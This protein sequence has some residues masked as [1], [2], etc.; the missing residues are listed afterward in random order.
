MTQR[1]S[2]VS[3][4][5]AITLQTGNLR[6]CIRILESAYD[7]LQK[8]DA[9]DILYDIYR[10]ACVKEF[11]L[12]LEQSG[13][14]LRKKLR[15]WFASNRQ[16]DRLVF[17]DV[18]RHAARRGLVSADA[19]ERWLEYRDNRNDTAH[20]YGAGFADATLKLLPQFIIDANALADAIEEPE[21]GDDV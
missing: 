10:A 15:P 16:V 1:P 13:K 8:H 19:G 17:K 20:D 2:A 12:V 9:D 3:C 5:R 18:V 4:R 6:R 14:L 11:E 7:G 21:P